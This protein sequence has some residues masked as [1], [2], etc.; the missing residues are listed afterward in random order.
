MHLSPLL[1]LNPLLSTLALSASIE[2]DVFPTTDCTGAATAKVLTGDTET[3][4]LS[5]GAAKMSAKALSSSGC[6]GKTPNLSSLSSHLS[7]LISLFSSLFPFPS[8]L[9]FLLLSLFSC[10]STTL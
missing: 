3:Q 6:T 9:F 4:C 7:F 2:V 10:L 8:S 1:L 5:I